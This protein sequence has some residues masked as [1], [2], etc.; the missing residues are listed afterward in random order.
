MSPGLC[1]L[2]QSTKLYYALQKKGIDAD[3][4]VV[5]GAQHGE[6]LFYQHEI[7]DRIIKFLDS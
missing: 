1:P 2:S 5:E 7:M 6:L 3:L 4:F